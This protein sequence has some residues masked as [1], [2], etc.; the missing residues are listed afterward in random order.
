MISTRLIIGAGLKKWTPQTRSGRLVAH[1]HLDDRQR[2][3]VGGQ[4]GAVLACLV[5]L[6]EQLEL[7]GRSST[8]DSMTRSQSARSASGGGG[9]DTGDGGVGV[10]LA[11]RAPWRRASR[12]TSA[13]RPPSA[14]ADSCLRERST[15]SK[16]EVAATCAMPDPMIP[17][18]MMPTLLI[19]MRH[20]VPSGNRASKSR[21]RRGTVVDLGD[22]RASPRPRH[23][24]HRLRADAAPRGAAARP[25]PPAGARRAAR[26]RVLDLGGAD[27]HRTLWDRAREVV[28][29]RPSWTASAT[30]GSRRW[31]PSGERFDTV[32]SVFQLAHGPGPRRGHR[33]DPGRAGRRRP[34]PV[35]R[36]RLPGRPHRSPPAVRR[37]TARRRHR[38][39]GRTGTSRW[40]CGPGGLSVIDIRRHRVPT[41]Q[42]WLR[43]V[44][45]G[46]AH[47][48]LE[49]G[50]AAAPAPDAAA[51]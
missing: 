49:P 2:R 6:V 16:P 8:T 24:P 27:T 37:P 44:L 5:E 21:W 46:V 45:D 11:H 41:L 12:G 34:A 30:P 51:S 38:L 50:G 22:W 25:R 7:G 3:G 10:L 39:A 29:R 23:H 48:A 14:S 33:R 13:S 42:P 18:P 19:V 17:E 47:H 43:Q 1:G 26:G 4:D 35:R 40:R 31:P 15:T 36:A 28:R 32:V 9:P 20:T